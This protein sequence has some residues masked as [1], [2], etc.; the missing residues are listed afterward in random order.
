MLAYSR[1]GLTKVLL[2][3]A[4]CF[5]IFTKPK[6]RLSFGKNFPL[7]GYSRSG[8]LKYLPQGNVFSQQ[9]P[10]SHHAA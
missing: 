2:A 3:F 7:C 4:F 8:L 10:K 9:T 5:N 6:V 1:L